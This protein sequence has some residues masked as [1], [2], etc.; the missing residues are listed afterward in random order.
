[1]KKLDRNAK[2]LVTAFEGVADA[3]MAAL[4]LLGLPA[5]APLTFAHD[6]LFVMRSAPMLKG[7]ATEGVAEATLSRL[8][9]LLPLFQNLAAAPYGVDAED[10]IKS[11]MDVDPDGT[12]FSTL[13]AYAHLSQVLP[14]A[15]RGYY[16]VAKTETGLA[17]THVDD[18]FAVAE[19]TDI[20]I[21]DLGLSFRF[22]PNPPRADPDVAAIANQLPHVNRGLLAMVVA[23]KAAVY[24]N[25]LAEARLVSDAALRE[26]LGMDHEVFGRIQSA[27]FGLA[28]TANEVALFL[29]AWWQHEHPD[30]N[31]MPSEA[32]EWCSVSMTPDFIRGLI[33]ATAN[34]DPEQV[35]RVID[36]FSI[37]YRQV[38]ARATGGDG[39]FPPFARFEDAVLFSP[40]LLQSFLS[41]RNAIYGF[42]N[43]SR[44]VIKAQEERGEPLTD[45]FGSLVAND[46]EPILVEQA[47]AALPA[48]TPWIVRSGVKIPGGEI[49][50]VIVDP[51][52]P[53]ALCIQAKAPLPPQGARLTARLGDRCEEGLRQ[54]AHLAN[55]PF[56]N[57]R[58]IL[59]ATAGVPLPGLTIRH[60]LLART[61]F[62]T[63][64]AWQAWPET[65]LLTSATLVLAARAS[66][67]ASDVSLASFI[68]RLERT[69]SDYIAGTNY[70]WEA[71]QI[72]VGTQT[73]DLPLL[74]FNERY[75]AEM[76]EQ[77]WPGGRP[78]ELEIADDRGLKQ[79]PPTDPAASQ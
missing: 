48:G 47:V 25:E 67:A 19:A 66:E 3:E 73:L 65:A 61:C 34:A 32:V 77:A 49:D 21:S 10:A 56:E 54:I 60:G 1:M 36:A 15:W 31:E 12:Q 46:L 74:K 22:H 9:Y 55:M 8:A 57:Q 76:R 5:R 50:L 30:S 44:E 69:I 27:F 14:E 68:A 64:E 71:G 53:I 17:L 41:S 59:E 37:D 42:A 28:E 35:D 24:R 18:T 16:E 38:P 33:A 2:N 58:Q 39:F 26:I 43:H 75:V 51:T 78:S 72:V 7:L 79:R 23:K 70:R 45:L 20:L 62:G 63:A 40:I 52:G 11:V 13:L 6:F 4:P 29:T